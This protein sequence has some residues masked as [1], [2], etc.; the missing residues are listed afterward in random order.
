MDKKV[1]MGK[2]PMA[3]NLIKTTLALRLIE[4]IFQKNFFIID[5][6]AAEIDFSSDIMMCQEGTNC[7]CRGCSNSG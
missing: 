1:S 7:D 6:S 4:A 2:V 5:P 3:I